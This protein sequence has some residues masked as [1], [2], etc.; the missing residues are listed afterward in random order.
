M[1]ADE[2]SFIPRILV[3]AL[4]GLSE[5]R[6]RDDRL[7]TYL[8][9]RARQAVVIRVHNQGHKPFD[10]HR[11]SHIADLAKAKTAQQTARFLAKVSARP[12]ET[13]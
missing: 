6:A 12:F 5:A 8:L 13:I 4:L 2:V 1:E 10:E 7:R 3:K 9:P 11:G